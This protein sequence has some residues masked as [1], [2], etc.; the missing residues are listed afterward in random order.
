MKS[1]GLEAEPAM[2]AMDMAK[3]RTSRERRSLAIVLKDKN[4]PDGMM[5]AR[6]LTFIEFLK[7]EL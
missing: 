6:K 2:P 1:L 4:D 7:R 3:E 5:K